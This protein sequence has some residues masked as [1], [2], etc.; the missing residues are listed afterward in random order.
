MICQICGKPYSRKAPFNPKTS[1]LC[2]RKAVHRNCK[3]CGGWRYLKDPNQPKQHKCECGID[4]TKKNLK[5]G[6]TLFGNLTTKHRADLHLVLFIIYRKD[7]KKRSSQRRALRR[8]LRQYYEEHDKKKCITTLKI[9][10]KYLKILKRQKIYE[11]LRNSKIKVK[12]TH[13]KWIKERI[14]LALADLKYE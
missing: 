6:Q 14:A 12:I 7:K 11:E 4:A 13:K 8:N 10:G 3:I 5:R 2:P 1:C 9:P